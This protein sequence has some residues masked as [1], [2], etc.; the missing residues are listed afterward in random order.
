MIRKA[1]IVMLSLAAAGTVAMWG[2]TAIE[3]PGYWRSRGPV[4]GYSIVRTAD[5]PP[6][7]LLV[8]WADSHL[9]PKA[10]FSE[11]SM[12]LRWSYPVA[13]QD[14]PAT[15]TSL[16][17]AGFEFR[18]Q[19]VPGALLSYTLPVGKTSVDV[20]IRIPLWFLFILFT[21]YPA[22]ALFIRGPLRRYLRRK[23]GLCVKCGYNLTGLPEPRC[24]ESG[25][26][27]GETC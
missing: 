23:K 20:D 8:S 13:Q 16:R 25:V 14:A 24:P 6:T 3:W 4:C 7:W 10:Q 18:R 21:S 1:I 17:L 27:I 22:V 5:Y 11:G 15:R 19:A 9:R 26:R 2:M 12:A